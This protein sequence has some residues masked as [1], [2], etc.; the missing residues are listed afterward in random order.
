MTKSKPLGH[1]LMPLKEPVLPSEP[2]GLTPI[3]KPFPSTFLGLITNVGQLR[4][5]K[6][7]ITFLYHLNLTLTDFGHQYKTL[8]TP[9]PKHAFHFL[10]L[11]KLS[12]KPNGDHVPFFY[13]FS[14]RGNVTES[15]I[16]T[17]IYCPD[18]GYC[19]FGISLVTHIP[20]H[21]LCTFPIVIV[22]YWVVLS[23]ARLLPSLL[24]PNWNSPCS[25]LCITGL[26]HQ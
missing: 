6:N 7:P 22:S 17:T 1:P 3:T 4:R 20:Y 2:T 23:F 14:V 10:P 9:K 11:T 26:V 15:T 5:S 12:W 21:V 25:L 16:V 8:T 24:V 18:I 13:F 19:L